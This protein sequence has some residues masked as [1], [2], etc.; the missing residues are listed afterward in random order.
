MNSPLSEQFDYEPEATNHTEHGDVAHGESEIAEA[1]ECL[2]KPITR[3]PALR[4]IMRP[5]PSWSV[6]HWLDEIVTVVGPARVVV[7]V[8]GG[9]VVVVVGGAVVV[10]VVGVG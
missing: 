10:V 5:I 1:H 3:A 7:V 6:S 4:K 9:T 2:E 8:V